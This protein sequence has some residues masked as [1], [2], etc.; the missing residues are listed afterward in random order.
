MAKDN[1]LPPCRFCSC[2]ATFVHDGMDP[3]YRKGVW[4]KHKLD[5]V[6]IK[7]MSIEEQNNKG[8]WMLCDTGCMHK[9][10]FY[11]PAN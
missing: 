4:E 8:K 1:K 7:K 6:C 3:I 5:N 2:D 10:H 11:E 9:C